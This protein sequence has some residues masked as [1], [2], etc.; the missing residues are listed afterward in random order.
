S[1]RARSRRSGR[2]RARSPRRRTGGARPWSEEPTA[3]RLAPAV[4]SPASDPR[5]L[6]A[7]PERLPARGVD[8]LPEDRLV[9]GIAKA[10]GVLSQPGPAGETSLVEL[11]GAYRQESEGKPGLGFV[12]LVHRLDRNVS[13]AMVVGKSSKA[14]S[15]LSAAF[16]SRE[17]VE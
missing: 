13:G 11:L 14:A 6:A 17:G 3:R 15:R 9:L 10:A 16:R 12:G 5:R 1:R 4:A 8:R 7:P 2:A